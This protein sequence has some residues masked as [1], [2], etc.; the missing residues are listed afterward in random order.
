[1]DWKEAEMNQK[2]I[3]QDLKKIAKDF[4]LKFD[5]KWFDFM[6]ITK[7]EGRYLEYVG[8]CWDPIY[9]PFGKTIKKRIENI[10]KFD[11]SKVLKKI[12][13]R[14]GGQ[15]ITKAEVFKGIKDCKKIKDNKLKKELINLHKR[16]KKKLKEDHLALLTKTNVKRQKEFL[17]KFVLKHEWIHELLFRNKIKFAKINFEKYWKYDEGLATYFDYYST[18]KLNYLEA[19]KKRTKH[20][21][22]KIYYVYA[23]RFREKLKGIE[24]PKERRE[25]IL[26]VLEKKRLK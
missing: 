11:K 14:F 12:I 24:S 4:D 1:M 6:W 13:K 7:K 3:K 17:F 18:N 2:K 23:I 5:N 21:S 25:V 19:M 16:I 15:M 8:M 20:P 9:S 26:D 10:E 22:A